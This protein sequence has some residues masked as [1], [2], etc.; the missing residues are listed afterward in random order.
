MPCYNAAEFVRKSAEA[1]LTQSTAD[2]ELII[3]D[4]CSSDGSVTILQELAMQDSRIKLI[5]HARNLGAS[6]SRND[7]LRCAGGQFVGFCD[8][9]DIW[10][11][12]KLELQIACLNTNV[13]YDVAYCDS[14]II[15]HAGR[16]TGELFSDQ[17]PPPRNP[18]GDLFEHLCL[19]NFV[20][21]QTVLLRRETVGGE[22][23]F[24]EHIKWVEDWWQWIRLS[25]KFKFF[26]IRRP[27]AQY[28][29]H[30]RST[31]FTQKPGILRNR[32]K[33]SRRTLGAFPDM[34]MRF[35]SVLWYQMGMELSQLHYHRL[36]RRFLWRALELGCRGRNSFREN[37]ATGIRLTIEFVR[38]WIA[39]SE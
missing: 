30:Q 9:D 28:R 5:L 12:D 15:D 29:V 39:F 23:Y 32:W 10:E 25:G 8:A 13:D 31:G 38:C 2:L 1:I 3:V 4:D 20:N 16:P 18:T 7:G 35:K 24:D 14:I 27:L 37:V 21:M 33:V 11:P 6:R 26:Y 36:A 19:R 17:F 34:P 22:I